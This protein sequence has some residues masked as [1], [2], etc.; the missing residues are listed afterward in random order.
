ML[1][2]IF[3]I[4]SPSAY[5]YIR[6]SALLPFP[7]PKTVRQH[8][9]S[10][11]TTCGYKEYADHALVFMWQSLSSNFCQTIGCFASNGEVKGK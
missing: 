3:N 9:A 10:F 7:H 5:K 6:E 4:R 8:L 1:C 11:K 2:L